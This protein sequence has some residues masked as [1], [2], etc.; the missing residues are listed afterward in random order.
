MN[1]FF[2]TLLIL[3]GIACFLLYYY[4]DELQEKIDDL[5]NL[6]K[7]TGDSVEDAINEVESEF[8]NVY[9][10]V[11]EEVN[12]IEEEVEET[13]DKVKEDFQEFD[14]EDV[15]GIGPKTK[16]KLLN[17]FKNLKSIYYASD[18][19]LKEVLSDRK[20][21]RLRSKFEEFLD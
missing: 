4:R 7:E 5:N 2:V 11:K 20:L 1:N 3:F 17:S 10:D 16:E 15:K 14:L 18:D 19:E 13:Y 12:E 8:E 6:K 21:E 9:E